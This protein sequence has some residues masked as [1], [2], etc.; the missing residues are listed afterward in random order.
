[1]GGEEEANEE[2]PKESMGGRGG[3]GLAATPREIMASTCLERVLWRSWMRPTREATSKGSL[4]EAGFADSMS[5]LV[6]SPWVAKNTG[7]ERRP[8][9]EGCVEDGG[10]WEC[11]RAGKEGGGVS[12]E[13]D[14]GTGADT[15]GREAGGW[16]PLAPTR[17]TKQPGGGG[18]LESHPGGGDTGALVASAMSTA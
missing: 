16:A 8:G 14:P 1:M 18:R 12:G 15:E 6:N 11:P 2:A 5:S 17:A 13:D 10:G 7:L 9:R 4:N 3:R